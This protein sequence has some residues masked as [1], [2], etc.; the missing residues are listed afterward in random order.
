MELIE[1]VQN[2]HKTG[3]LHLDIK[4]DNILISQTNEVV[5]ID[6]GQARKFKLPDGT[7]CP[8]TGE[9]EWGNVH[10]ASPNAFKDQTLSRRDDII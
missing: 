1:S 9:M 7:H 3:Y 8:D 5:L 4:L 10:F 2:M 6:Y